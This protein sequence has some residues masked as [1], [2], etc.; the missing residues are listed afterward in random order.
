[1]GNKKRSK[2]EYYSNLMI[3]KS[4]PEQLYIMMFSVIEFKELIIRF[5]RRDI[6]VRYKQSILGLLWVFII[7][8]ISILFFVVLNKSGV[9]NLEKVNIPYP[10]YAIVGITCWQLFSNSLMYSINA[11]VGA[12]GMIAKIN[13]PKSTLI[14]AAI[15]RAFVD[16]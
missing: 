1:M 3:K 11:L 16:V 6:T 15:G 13:F 7:P 14:F 4:I 5:L 9:M 12:G 2:V 8:V 10:L